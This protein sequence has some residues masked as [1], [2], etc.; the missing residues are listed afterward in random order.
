MK[1]AIGLVGYFRDKRDA[2]WKTFVRI[3]FGVDLLNW[4]NRIAAEP[5]AVT[6]SRP[7]PK[8]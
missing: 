3:T 7:N 2:S 5:S 6:L 4:S 1:Y 8:T